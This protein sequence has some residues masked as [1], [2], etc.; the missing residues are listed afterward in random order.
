MGRP[1]T[2]KFLFLR[3]EEEKKRS[4]ACRRKRGSKAK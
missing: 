2:K 4:R 3:R 1:Y